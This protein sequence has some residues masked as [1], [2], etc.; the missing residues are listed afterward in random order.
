MCREQGVKAV[1]KTVHLVTLIGK[2]CLI[3]C[4]FAYVTLLSITGYKVLYSYGIYLAAQ[5]QNKLNIQFPISAADAGVP[6]SLEI[7]PHDCEKH[8]KTLFTL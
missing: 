5:Q 2:S 6:F 7:L 8:I 4:V 1:H 3:F